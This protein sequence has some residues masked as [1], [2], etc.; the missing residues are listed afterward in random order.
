MSS[1]LNK[2][3][4]GVTEVFIKHDYYAGLRVRLFDSDGFIYEDKGD[5]AKKTDEQIKITGKLYPAENILNYK[6][7]LQYHYCEDSDFGSFPRYKYII[8]EGTS[9]SSKSWSLEEW[10]LR[11][12][13]EKPNK[14]INIWRDT[15]EALSGTIWKDFRKLIPLSGRSIKLPQQTKPIYFENGSII[16]PK[17]T[18]VNNTHGTTQDIAWLNEPYNI[19]ED[20]F[21]QIDQRANQ[22]IIDMNPL[23]LR[24]LDKVRNSKRCKVIYSTFKNNPFCPHDQRIKILSYEP[25]ESG[26]Y[27]VIEGVP[28]YKGFPI[29]IHNQPPPHLENVKRGTANEYKWLVYGLGI[30]AEKQSKIYH[31]WSKITLQDYK[32]LNYQKYYGL[33]YGRANPTACV[34]IQFDGERTFYVRPLLYQPMNEMTAPLGEV[35]ISVGVPVGPVTYV[36]AD[37]ADKDEGE[38]VYFTND[39]RTNYAIN[40]VKTSKPSYKVRFDFISKAKIVYVYDENFEFEYDNYEYWFIQGV[41][42]EKPIK[43]NDHYMDSLAYGI[44][45][46][47]DLLQLAF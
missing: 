10:S 46:I 20:E 23:N 26:S 38:D 29:S 22:V 16:E 35:L 21:D 18:D 24:W 27:E 33:D 14:H 15:R 1:N 45:G 6:S 19:T 34:E 3:K 40:A 37:S 39:L 2:L 31:G 7:D 41:N 11:Y 4:Y 25:W 36:W 30:K 8:H 32:K 44:F 12:C 43:K 13:E 9:R 42:T 28:T 5:H 47:K 17:G